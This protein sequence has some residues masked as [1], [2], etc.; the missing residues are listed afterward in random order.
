MIPCQRHAFDIP[1]DVAYF[2][3]AYMAP[4]LKVVRQAAEEALGRTSQ[5]WRVTPMDFFTP[6]E[7]AR[8]LFAQLIGATADDIAIVSSASYGIST[9]AKNLRLRRGQTILLLEGEFPSNVYPWYELARRDGGTLRFVPRPADGDWTAAILRALDDDVAIAA[10]PHCHWTDGSLVDLERVSPALQERGA[11]L[12]LDVT[13]SLGAQPL[14]VSRVKID[15][16]ACA[17][18][19]WLLGPN[20]LA[21]LYAS[22]EHHGGDPLDYNWI[23]R[24]R[25]ED[26][27]GLVNYREGYQAGARRYDMGERSSFVLIPMAIAALEQLLAWTPAAIMATLGAITDELAGRL[28]ELGVSSLPAPLRSRHILGVQFTDGGD[29]AAGLVERLRARKVFVSVRGQTAR[30]APH[31]WI[32]PRD[33]A[34]LLEAVA[35]LRAR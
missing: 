6:P 7:R 28:R 34:R 19:K 5:P 20:G 31:L 10:L 3:C 22:P 2:N 21:F 27:A 30:L 25:S 26:F 15:F 13:Q 12:V 14:D 32:T 16:L 11:K 18:Y 9:A 33:T 1:D 8:A 23:N 4:T 24:E 29:L 35:E 17:A